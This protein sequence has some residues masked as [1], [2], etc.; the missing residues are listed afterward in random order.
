MTPLGSAGKT[1]I[2]ECNG[3]QMPVFGM[4]TW[5]LRGET[6]ERMVAEALALGVRHIDTAR[7]YGNEREVGAGIRASKV[8]RSEIFLT[9]KILPRELATDDARRAAADSLANLDVGYIDLL[10]IHWPNKD[11]P[12]NET[13]G[14]F[15]ELKR[16]GAVK[17]IGVSDFTAAMV[18]EAVA[19]CDEP[20]VTNQVE[21]H[22]YLDQTTVLATCRRHG[23][24]VTAYGPLAQGKVTGDS[25]LKSIGARYGKSAGQAALRWL[26]QHDGVAVIPR[27]SKRERLAE[28]AAIFDFALSDDEMQRISS[29]ARGDGRLTQSSFAPKWD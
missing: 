3:A 23:M 28:N 29:L 7:M 19:L 16:S 13:L 11:V 22:P 1:P 12:L 10:L 24:S 21:F 18:D 14:V 2:I 8:A 6:A 27:S 9:T 25:L 15:T 20:L 26:I 4:G 17:H 5:A